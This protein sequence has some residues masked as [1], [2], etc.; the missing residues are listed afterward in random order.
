ME[1]I[2]LSPCTRRNDGKQTDAETNHTK[3]SF[4]ISNTFFESVCI[5]FFAHYLIRQMTRC[6]SWVIYPSNR[7]FANSICDAD[8][9]FLISIMSQFDSFSFSIAGS[10][11]VILFMNSVVI[12]P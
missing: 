6:G 11:N 1:L 10:L 5:W 9:N 12:S 8:N 4:Q 3:A 2:K 7:T